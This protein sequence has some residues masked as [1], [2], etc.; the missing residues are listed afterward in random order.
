MK[1]TNGYWLLRDNVQA[2]YATVAFDVEEG[3][4]EQGRPSLIIYAPTKQINHRGDTLNGTLLTISYSSPMQDVIRVRVEHF[5]GTKDRGPHYEL[6]STGNPE[7]E[8][9]NKTNEHEANTQNNGNPYIPQVYW[10]GTTAAD[11]LLWQGKCMDSTKEEY[12]L[13][14]QAASPRAYFVAGNLSIMVDLQAKGWKAEVLGHSDVITSWDSKSTAYMLVDTKYPYMVDSLRLSP[15]ETI[16]G[17]G[18]RFGPLVKNGQ[19]IDIW[20]EDGGTASEQAYKN[21]PFCLSNRGYGLFINATNKVS[22]EIASEKTSRLQFSVPGETIEYYLIYGPTPKEILSKYTLL[23]GRPALPPPWAFGL[24]LTTSFTTSY[25][26]KTVQSFIDGM[27]AREIPLRVFHFDC[28]WMR[29]YQ[30]IDLQWDNRTFP[31]PKGMLHRLK[32]QGLSICVWINPYVAQRSPLFDEAVQHNFLLKKPNGDIWQTDMWQAGMGIIDFTNPAATQWFQ[33]KLSSLIDMGV[34]CFKTD[35]GERIPTDVV[36]F[37]GSDP[38][39]MHNYYTFLYNKCVFQ[40]LEQKKGNGKAVLFARSA[41]V[42]SQRFPA[43]WGGDCESTYEAMAETLRGGLSLALSGFGFWSHDIGGFEGMPPSDLYKRWLAFG[44]L[45]PLSRLHGSSSYR[46]P[47]LF[48]EE[49]VTVAR[50]FTRLKCRL[51]PYLY[52]KAVEAHTTGIS[53]LRPMIV[54]FP[55]DP[56]CTYIDLQYM[57]GDALLVVPIS[58]SSGRVTLYVPAGRW[59]NRFRNEVIE[60]P[61]WIETACTYHELPLL[62]RPH[63]ILPIG[64]VDTRPDYS[65]TEDVEF[66]VYQLEDNKEAKVIIPD[67]SGTPA[68]SITI[69]KN[70]GIYNISAKGDLHRWSVLLLAVSGEATILSGHGT[71]EMTERGL[72]IQVDTH[73]LVVGVSYN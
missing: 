36:Y 63:T 21:I 8:T 12:A 1:F 39:K 41:T 5:R 30:W 69:H 11:R 19:T 50:E 34:D 56:N 58:T 49:A 47:W 7:I 44:L 55:E 43:H 52:Q 59:T 32:Q 26:E 23:T 10:E 68:A 29:E 64:S 42:G 22:F 60:G 61:C 37:D 3:L 35:F 65:Y 71:V 6:Y 13:N 57:L 67:H 14:G 28:F 62:V 54:E 16:Y 33:E 70:A 66:E 27:K 15:G 4:D 24:W 18:E 31:D 72:R 46:V 48:D 45:S 20:N 40:V 9:I 51:M 17:L 73:H 53:M 38:I 2:S 25:D